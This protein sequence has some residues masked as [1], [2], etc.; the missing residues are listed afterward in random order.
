MNRLMKLSMY[1]AVVFII[2]FFFSN[3]QGYAV[4]EKSITTPLFASEK[5]IILNETNPNIVKQINLSAYSS[6]V[7]SPNLT[8]YYSIS[9]QLDDT[10][11]MTISIDNKPLKT[12]SLS[13]QL[14]EEY[15]GRLSLNLEGLH[16][17]GRNHELSIESTLSLTENQCSDKVNKSLWIKVSPES[18]IEIPYKDR[19]AEKA[20][21]KD[22]PYSLIP[23]KGW[24]EENEIENENSVISNHPIVTIVYPEKSSVLDNTYLIRLISYLGRTLSMKPEGIEV[25]SEKDIELEEQENDVIYVGM[26]N[27]FSKETI[28]IFSDVVWEMS[29]NSALL[30]TNKLQAGSQS[31]LYLLGAFNENGM[32]LSLKRLN[33]RNYL[34][35][36]E[37]KVSYIEKTFRDVVDETSKTM[38]PIESKKDAP[39]DLT[40][41]FNLQELGYDSDLI[42]KNTN[43]ASISVKYR[44]P[45]GMALEEGSK[46]T[47]FHQYNDT[48][49]A[50]LS[51]VT[52]IVNNTPVL[53][54]PLV[55][56]EGENTNKLEI[57]IPKS[58]LKS[59]VMII[60]LTY[61]FNDTEVYDCGERRR[62][63][64]WAKVLNTSFFELEFEKVN[65]GDFNHFPY[66]I[67]K[68]GVWNNVSFVLPNKLK[69]TDPNSLKSMIGTIL[70]LSHY[71]TRDDNGLFL[72]LNDEL[73]EKDYQ[74]KNLFF[75][76]PW[77]ESA[78][79]K[80]NSHLFP[81]EVNE[82]TL[83]FNNDFILAEL[84]AKKINF[85]YVKQSPWNNNH[86]MM[87]LSTINDDFT[88]NNFAYLNDF[89]KIK[90]VIIDH[91]QNYTEVNRDKSRVDTF[92]FGPEGSII[93]LN[94]LG[95]EGVEQQDKSKYQLNEN[96]SSGSSPLKKLFQ[97]FFLVFTLFLFVII[98]T[99]EKKKRPKE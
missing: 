20:S 43:S 85:F 4:Y 10:A 88:N 3:S 95:E 98:W 73:S 44:P 81:L 48:Y 82:N 79:L 60:T 6:L 34:S 28:E 70:S 80:E 5:E 24:E 64:G 40:Q 83:K 9:P 50:N 23:P 27:H 53:T 67:I 8:L 97:V 14:H 31:R 51:N 49:S 7:S 61:A 74:D 47:F 58:E 22:F 16:L 33:D 36:L 96:R 91:E 93:V 37:G 89:S 86:F 75:H 2:L 71:V 18:Y 66:P 63:D 62:A 99:L 11:S 52:V 17:S 69:E 78:F 39:N 25:V 55:E 68:N 65:H 57:A 87:L 19:S 84:F 54:T 26:I 56:G 29:E 59:E 77:N 30:T 94:S 76:S 15:S 42:I 38:V 21:L 12:I 35:S 41:T 90:K 72:F 45:T 46:I 32:D 92:L 1:V 13:P